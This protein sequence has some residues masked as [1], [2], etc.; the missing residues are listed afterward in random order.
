MPL[1]VEHCTCINY[2]MAFYPLF[3]DRIDELLIEFSELNNKKL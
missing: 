3:K 1:C 2:K